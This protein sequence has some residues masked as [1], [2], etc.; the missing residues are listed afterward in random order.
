MGAVLALWQM[1]WSATGSMF[2]IG[3]TVTVNELGNPEHA[4]DTGVTV[5]KDVTGILER[6][7]AVKVLIAVEPEGARPIFCEFVH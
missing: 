4:F 2:G 6:F 3:L 5:I 7:V 1:R